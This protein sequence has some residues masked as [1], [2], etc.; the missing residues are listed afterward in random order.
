MVG[1]VHLAC[2]Q[3]LLSILLSATVLWRLA[4]VL[5]LQGTYVNQQ[6]AAGSDT[7]SSLDKVC[8]NITGFT[9]LAAK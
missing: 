7:F 6:I 5:C 9:A 8:I 3:E 2:N 1:L 4:H